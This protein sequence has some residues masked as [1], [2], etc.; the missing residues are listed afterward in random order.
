MRFSTQVK[1]FSSFHHHRILTYQ[2][3]IG[4][5][6]HKSSEGFGWQE[7]YYRKSFLRLMILT[8]PELLE[9]IEAMDETLF[10]ELFEKTEEE[11]EA[12]KVE[13][14]DRW[15]WETGTDEDKVRFEAIETM[16]EARKRT[17]LRK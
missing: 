15:N 12:L 14:Y 2:P 1:D 3:S 9:V 5:S 8:C 16:M 6:M 11:L 10:N 7:G 13:A 4:Y 17:G